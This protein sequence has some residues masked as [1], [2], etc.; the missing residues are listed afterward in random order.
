MGQAADSEG[1]ARDEG[2]DCRDVGRCTERTYR[3]T[4]PGCSPHSLALLS[5]KASP[6]VSCSSV[7][8]TQPQRPPR[9]QGNPGKPRAAGPALGWGEGQQGRGRGEL[10][11]RLPPPDPAGLSHVPQPAR[12]VPHSSTR[13]TWEGA[14]GRRR[15]QTPH[16]HP[17]PGLWSIRVCLCVCASCSLSVSLFLPQS[18]SLCCHVCF[19]LYFQG[20]RCL[21]ARAGCGDPARGGA[22]TVPLSAPG[23]LHPPPAQSDPRRGGRRRGRG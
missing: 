15:S 5:P 23:A 8:R 17:R 9:P 19:S 10:A 4:D 12:P 3:L 21:A 6:S 20:S 13:P 18:L 14:W 1:E 7:T 2:Q 16:T 11:S 22:I